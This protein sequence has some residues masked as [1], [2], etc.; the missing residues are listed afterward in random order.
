MKEGTG[1][2]SQVT[3]ITKPDR[4]ESLKNELDKIGIGGMT[5]TNVMGMGVQKGQTTY[6]RGAEVE[7]KLLPKMKVEIVVSEV[8]VQKV[9]DA[10][11]KALYTG[12]MGDGKIFVY[13]VEQVVR[14]ST[15]QKGKDALKYN[16][17]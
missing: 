3:I 6:Y 13:D 1:E 5:V 8:P 16:E 2:F 14:I 9:I 4:F 17:A 7:S 15:G 11:R 10:T 12:Q